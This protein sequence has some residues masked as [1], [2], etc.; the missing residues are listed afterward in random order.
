MIFLLNLTA[1]WISFQNSGFFWVGQEKARL[2]WEK[3]EERAK[4]LKVGERG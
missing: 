4:T 1:K 3:E 2:S